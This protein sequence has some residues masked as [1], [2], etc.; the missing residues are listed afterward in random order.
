MAG[1]AI[2]IFSL[3]C[4]GTAW[5]PERTRLAIQYLENQGHPVVCGFLTGKS[6]GY[7]SGTISE[8]AE[9]LNEL[10][11]NPRVKCI[12]ASAGGYVSNSILPYID[13]EALQRH[14]K[15]LVGFSDVTAILLAAYAKT[16]LV[17]FL[18]PNLIPVFGEVPPYSEESYAYFRQ[19]AAGDYQLPHTFPVPGVWTEDSVGLEE[20]GVACT[21]RVNEVICV[22]EGTAEGRLLGGNLNT[23]QGIFGSPYMP[24]IKEGDMLYL[25]K[26]RGYP[27]SIERSISMLEISGVLQRISGLILGKCADYNAGGLN[28]SFWEVVMETVGKYSFPIL[29]EFDCAHTRPMLTLPIGCRVRLNAGKKMVELLENATA[30][31]K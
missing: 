13:Y 7:R 29:A 6:E 19:I 12:M 14:P 25:G 9:E 28:K 22:R 26:N 18:G 20:T 21:A 16:G 10:I 1:D 15:I 30:Q 5:I 8:R 11:R 3:S 17:T 23:L 4:P 24:D 2:G 27:E 31:C